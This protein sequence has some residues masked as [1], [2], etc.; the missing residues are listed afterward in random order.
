LCLI[1]IAIGDPDTEPTSSVNKV[2]RTIDPANE[3]VAL[4]CI[5]LEGGQ[6]LGSQ[7]EVTAI[8]GFVT[9]LHYG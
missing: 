1:E 3:L 7:E 6:I 2:I 5:E 9:E 4:S 8:T